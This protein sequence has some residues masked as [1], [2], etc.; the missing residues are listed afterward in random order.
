MVAYSVNTDILFLLKEIKELCVAIRSL[1]GDLIPS[2]D[3]ATEEYSGDDIKDEEESPKRVCA[4][5]SLP[6]KP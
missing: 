1:L 3:E 5:D 4:R 6:T 2:D